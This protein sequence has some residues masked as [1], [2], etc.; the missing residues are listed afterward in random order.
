MRYVIDKRIVKS[1]MGV[2]CGLH[3]IRADTPRWR[4]RR[5]HL[6]RRFRRNGARCLE[7][8]FPS[9]EK[10]GGLKSARLAA[11]AAAF[12][13]LEG[14]RAIFWG[15]YMRLCLH[16]LYMGCGYRRCDDDHICV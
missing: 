13:V 14:S 3:R 10:I 11:E 8:L 9:R 1:R 5:T 6:L 12:G 16:Y 4:I 7:L 15:Q 2:W